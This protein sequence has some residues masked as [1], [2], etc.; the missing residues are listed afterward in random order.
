MKR[1]QRSFFARPAPRVAPDLLGKLLV[2]ADEGL[3]ARIVEAEAYT[4]D[5]PACH[6]HGGRTARNAPLFGPPGNAYV[7]FT[8][9][10]HWC[11]NAATA[12]EGEGQGC[13]LRAAQPLAGLAVMRA[14]RG[15]RPDR[16]LL[17]GPARLAQAFGLDGTWSG[18]DLCDEGPLYLA[19]DGA[20]PPVQ[21]G[22]RVGV[23]AAADLPW[24]FVVAGSPWA[25]PY[26]R[27][28]RA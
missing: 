21:A 14:R 17:R 24:R 9:G 11:L 25:S 4:Q 20:L 10:M 13:L 7:Y 6:A 15:Q 12:A 19:D 26:R 18:R 2:R 23:V 8:Y 1:L 16:E 3:V 22:P 28:A 5:E 27:H